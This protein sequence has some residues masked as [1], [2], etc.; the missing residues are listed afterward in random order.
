MPETLG[1]QR[2]VIELLDLM[3]E[4]FLGISHIPK[5]RAAIRRQH[6]HHDTARERHGRQQKQACLQCSPAP[7]VI[8]ASQL[9]QT[10]AG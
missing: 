4:L 5:H 3:P 7:A 6:D 10:L 2:C 1:A 8:Q 9:V